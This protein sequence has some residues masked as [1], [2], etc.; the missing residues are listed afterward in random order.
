METIMKRIHKTLHKEFPPK[1]ILLEDAGDG[2]VGGWVISKSF[3]GLT[4]MERQRK[5]WNLFEK[6]LDEKDVPLRF[7]EQKLDEIICGHFGWEIPEPKLEEWEEIV[8]RMNN[9]KHQLKIAV[10]GK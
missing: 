7:H 8:S 10:C 1:G 9:P 6:F 4:G 5:V 2:F 3:E